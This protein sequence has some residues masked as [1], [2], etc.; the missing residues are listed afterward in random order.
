MFYANLH[1]AAKAG[2]SRDDVL[3]SDDSERA[4]V[5]RH[6]GRFNASAVLALDS[7]ARPAASGQFNFRFNRDGTLSGRNTDPMDTASFNALL[8]ATHDRLAEFGR[9]ILAGDALVNPYRN[10]RTSACDRCELGSVCRIEPRT[11]RFRALVEP[12]RR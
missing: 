7:G 2:G 4:A 9:R 8:L 5:Y 6:L 3:R 11:H 10:G 1:G 12:P